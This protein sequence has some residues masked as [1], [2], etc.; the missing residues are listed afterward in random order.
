[1]SAGTGSCFRTGSYHYKF[2]SGYI[3]AAS[4]LAQENS[5]GSSLPLAGCTCTS[6]RL[7]GMVCLPLRVA[8]VAPLLPD[9]YVPGSIHL[10]QSFF[11]FIFKK[12]VQCD[13]R[14]L[15]HGLWRVRIHASL[16]YIRIKHAR[17]ANSA[18]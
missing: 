1:M 15:I 12:I 3:P 14:R 17:A 18:A 7:K 11:L 8:V 9:S 16:K 13:F 4:R 5:S 6:D 10:L 2:G